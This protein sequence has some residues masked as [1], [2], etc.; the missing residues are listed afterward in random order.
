MRRLKM[1]LEHPATDLSVALIMIGT[2]LSESWQTL[3]TDLATLSLGAR[4][5]VLVFGFANLLR[6]LPQL[7]DAAE[8]A[9]HAG[10]AD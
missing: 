5:G 10:N 7:V 4:H 6:A 9:R 1:L 2:S 8:H 3:S